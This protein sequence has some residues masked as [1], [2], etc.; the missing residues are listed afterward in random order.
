MEKRKTAWVD[1]SSI[2][3]E[4]LPIS[5]R[6]ARKFVDLYLTPKRVG[7]RIYIQRTQ[8]E[9]LLADPDRENFPLDI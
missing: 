7:N 8:L 1:I 4:Y 5:R 2:V 6:K 9:R 3:Q